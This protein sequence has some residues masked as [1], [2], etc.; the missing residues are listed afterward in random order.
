ATLKRSD[1]VGYENIFDEIVYQIPQEKLVQEGWLCRPIVV[2]VETKVDIRNVEVRLDF[3]IESLTAFVNTP[4][5]NAIVIHEYLKHVKPLCCLTRDDIQGKLT[6]LDLWVNGGRVSLPPEH[7]PRVDSPRM[8]KSTLVFAASVEHVLD[9]YSAFK[10]CGVDSVGYVHGKMP[11]E[12]R[13]K[14]L[15]QYTDGDLEVLINCSI[16]TEG[17]DIPNVDCILLARPTTSSALLCQMIGRG[18]RLHSGKTD[19]LIIDFHDLVS[20]DIIMPTLT[21]LFPNNEIRD[22]EFKHAED[23]NMNFKFKMSDNGRTEPYYDPVDYN[24]VTSTHNQETVAN[25]NTAIRYIQRYVKKYAEIMIAPTRPTSLQLREISA[26]T[27]L[28]V[29]SCHGTREKKIMILLHKLF[30]RVRRILYG[31]F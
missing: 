21:G 6:E 20:D 12:K 9:L 26:P 10:I 3:T 28:A 2:S 30:K 13:F 15:K 22:T 31:E 5:R 27:D 17:V 7:F 1:G 14:M 16:L 18:L 29:N 23:L 25:A 4:E 19:C 11:V 8:R 24:H